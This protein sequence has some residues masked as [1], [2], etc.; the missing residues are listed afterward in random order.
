M[1]FFVVN[2]VVAAKVG[3]VTAKH[4]TAW[5]GVIAG[6]LTFGSMIGFWMWVGHVAEWLHNRRAKQ[7]K[8]N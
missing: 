4:T 1:S 5:I 6:I 3:I 8:K 7:R 2:L